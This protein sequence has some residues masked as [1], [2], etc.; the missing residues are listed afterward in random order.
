MTR[1]ARSTQGRG[2]TMHPLFRELYLSGDVDDP[3]ETEAE[4]RSARA[5]ARARARLR[6]LEKRANRR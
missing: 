5:G 2:G 1:G 4:R 6:L 3:D